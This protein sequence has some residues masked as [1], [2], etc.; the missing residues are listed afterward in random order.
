MKTIGSMTKDKETEKFTKE[1]NCVFI[2]FKQKFVPI[3][4]F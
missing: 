4:K 2:T 3:K 1:S